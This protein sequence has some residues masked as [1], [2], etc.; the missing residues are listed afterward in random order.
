M[1]KVSLAENLHADDAF[2]LSAHLLDDADDGV[3]VGVHVGA[4]GVE[5]NEVDLDPRRCSGSAE[6]A[7]AVAGDAVRA[8]DALLLG[9]GEDVHDAAVACGP[10]GFGDAVD[11]DDVDVVDA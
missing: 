2:A 3:G 8:N 5:A 4:D 11:E 1:A 10:V 7:D 6:C 9:F